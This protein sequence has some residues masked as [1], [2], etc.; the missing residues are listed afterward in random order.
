VWRHK[1]VIPE[2]R[3]LRQEDLEFKIN[4]SYIRRSCL[5]K[6]KTNNNNKNLVLLISDIEISLAR[7]GGTCL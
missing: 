6:K 7:H 3:R 2:L 5:K 4:L 1:P